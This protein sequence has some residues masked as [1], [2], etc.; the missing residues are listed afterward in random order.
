MTEPGAEP[1]T[2]VRLANFVGPRSGGLRTALYELGRGYRAA[3]HDPVLVV[4]GPR[5]E[6]NDTPQGRVITL[7]GPTVPWMGGYRVVVGRRRLTALLEELRPDRLEVS[8]RTTLRWTGAWARRHGIASIMVSHENLTALL[9]MALPLWAPVRRIADSLN[10]RTAE[11]FDTVVATTEFA[12]AEFRRIGATGLVKVPLGVDLARF[13][14]GLRDASLRASLARPSELLLVHCGRLSPEKRVERSVDAL[15]ALRARGVSAVLVV[16]GDGPRR[17]FLERRARG[18]PVRF[19]GFVPDRGLVARLL[20]TADA[21][22]APGPA[23]TFGL[24][25]L[26]AMACGTPVV[27]AGDGALGEVVGDAGVAVPGSTGFRFAEA[28]LELAARPEADRRSAAR[29]RAQ[30]FG[31][32]TAVSGMLAAHG[33]DALQTFEEV[34]SWPGSTVRA[35]ASRRSGTR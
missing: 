19:L 25:A 8:D 21:V 12:A 31:W 24:A 17:P 20:A 2:I 22:L 1:A 29:Q 7:P 33:L 35:S 16:V 15:A 4:P 23:E 13:H 28:V 27:A 26:E 11:T 30:R 3:G 34:A 14:P 5:F 10:Q 18:L 6:E 32:P 9:E